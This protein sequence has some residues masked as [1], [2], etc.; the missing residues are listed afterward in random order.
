MHHTLCPH[1]YPSFTLLDSSC[2]Y[3]DMQ[4]YVA[5]ADQDNCV[6]TLG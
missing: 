6:W 5:R 4:T 3:T 1:T 2:L